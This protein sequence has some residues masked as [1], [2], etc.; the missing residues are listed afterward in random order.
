MIDR[1]HRLIR[2][3]LTIFIACSNLAKNRIPV[4]ETAQWLP[5]NLTFRQISRDKLE[6]YLFPNDSTRFRKHWNATDDDFV[7]EKLIESDFEWQASD[8]FFFTYFRRIV[9]LVLLIKIGLW[10][11]G[12]CCRF[13]A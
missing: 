8:G 2:P 10:T 5:L 11:L 4:S 13:C 3:I 6:K 1:K 12:N 9:F 7:R